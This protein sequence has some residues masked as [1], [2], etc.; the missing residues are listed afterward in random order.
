MLRST[1]AKKKGKKVAASIWPTFANVC[2]AR[3]HLYVEPACTT[4]V[5]TLYFIN[6]YMAAILLTAPPY[7]GLKRGQIQNEIITVPVPKVTPLPKEWK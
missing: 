5:S 7:F 2:K 3:I 6:A 4:I 1:T